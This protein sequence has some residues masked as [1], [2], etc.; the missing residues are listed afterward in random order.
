MKN[1]FRRIAHALLGQYTAE[2][3]GG[4]RTYLSGARLW[5][6]RDSVEMTK[7]HELVG[8]YEMFKHIKE[9]SDMD[10]YTETKIVFSRS[11]EKHM[12]IVLVLVLFEKNLRR[13]ERRDMAQLELQYETFDISEVT[14]L[15]AAEWFPRLRRNLQR[16]GSLSSVM[17]GRLFDAADAQHRAGKSLLERRNTP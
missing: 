13:G 12:T 4:S 3:Y 11:G 16:S 7:V 6:H 1:H 9:F 10:L 2:L 8:H 14:E 17:V 15:T 5:L